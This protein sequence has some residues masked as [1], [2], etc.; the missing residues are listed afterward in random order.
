MARWTTFSLLTATAAS[1][2][3]M[4]RVS[5][6]VLSAPAFIEACNLP[7]PIGYW[8]NVSAG[9]P[10]Q[11]LSMLFSVNGVSSTLMYPVLAQ[12]PCTEECQ[13]NAY[14]SLRHGPDVWGSEMFWY[15]EG[16]ET[17]MIGGEQAE[18]LRFRLVPLADEF[19]AVNELAW[20]GTYKSLVR[21]KLIISSSFSVWNTPETNDAG[22]TFGGINTAQYH[23]PLHCFPM[24][25]RLSG[26]GPRVI[27]PVSGVEDRLLNYDFPEGPFR[28]RTAD[29]R[30]TVTSVPREA[31]M[32][33]YADLDLE[34][35]SFYSRTLIPCVRRTEDHILTFTIGNTT[36]STP[37]AA[38]ISDADFSSD[39]SDM[40]SFDIHP[41]D[42]D[43]SDNLTGELGMN[44]IQHLYLVVDHDTEMACVALLNPNPGLDEILEIGPG[45][46]VPDA[47]VEFPTDVTRYAPPTPPA[48]TVVSTQ[49]AVR[50]AIPAVAVA[51][52]TGLA[53]VM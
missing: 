34:W 44:V 37:W 28:V 11:P 12:P 25:L 10:P 14:E 43:N 24:H 13:E 52:I 22:I 35:D 48:T 5:P 39:P 49:G 29:K 53:F 38:F 30:N 1:T 50:M 21:Q 18:G 16:L 8:I 32:Q 46:H 3:P 40:C 45:L 33:L 2:A 6:I 42:E 20:D 31:V 51:G 26:L 27:L 19:S 47:V 9:T 41:M 15:Q 17:L 36:I 7:I 4:K 23:G